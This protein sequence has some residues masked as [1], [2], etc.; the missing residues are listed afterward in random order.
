MVFRIVYLNFSV[1]FNLYIVKHYRM[2]Q[3]LYYRVLIQ[4]PRL[5]ATEERR[6]FAPSKK[7]GMPPIKA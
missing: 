2:V 5:R 1:V 6:L 7:I 4:Q 3:T